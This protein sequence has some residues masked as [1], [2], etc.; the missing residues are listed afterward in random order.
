[1]HII[2]TFQSDPAIGDQPL[3]QKILN[4]YVR[5]LLGF[6]SNKKFVITI[7][8]IT[9]LLPYFTNTQF[10]YAGSDAR[11][12]IIHIGYPLAI[13]AY[14][15]TSGSIYPSPPGIVLLIIID[16]LAYLFWKFFKRMS[17]LFLKG[18]HLEPI[19]FFFTKSNI[20]FLWLLIGLSVSTLGLSFLLKKDNI[21]LGQWSRIGQI[22]NIYTFE[23]SIKNDRKDNFTFRVALKSPLEGT[24]LYQGRI[25]YLKTS[26]LRIAIYEISEIPIIRFNKDGIDEF[27]NGSFGQRMCFS[28]TNI[29][30]DQCVCEYRNPFICFEYIYG[31]GVYEVSCHTLFDDTKICK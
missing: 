13:A 26:R 28:N 31:K 27:Y 16:L 8:F 22:T 5:V 14:D 25:K 15:H 23:F 9:H 20:Q 24:E 1:L 6:I 19:N 3:N 2:D 12:I 4:H 10:R 21:E 29:H 18:D 30:L 17:H 7:L 11:K